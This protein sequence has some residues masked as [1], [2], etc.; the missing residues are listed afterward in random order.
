M[1]LAGRV[2]HALSDLPAE[3]HAALRLRQGATR[4]ERFERGENARPVLEG[5]PRRPSLPRRRPD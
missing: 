1:R 3:Q 5:S 4:R 2:R